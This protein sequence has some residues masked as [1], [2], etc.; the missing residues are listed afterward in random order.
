MQYIYIILILFCACNNNNGKSNN[1]ND[2]E[3]KHR[4]VND[5][6]FIFKLIENKSMA[7]DLNNYYKVKYYDSLININFC[8]TEFDSVLMEIYTKFIDS[9]I[10]KRIQLGVNKISPTEFKFQAGEFWYCKYEKG[11]LTLF[12]QTLGHRNKIHE[13]IKYK[14]IN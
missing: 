10:G 2:E 1:K 6:S 14:Y 8:T 7:W 4:I 5:T 3:N 9:A 12:V 13:F 11:K